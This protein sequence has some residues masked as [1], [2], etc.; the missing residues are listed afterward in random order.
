MD[1]PIKKNIR[2]QLLELND[3]QGVETFK[4]FNDHGVFFNLLLKMIKGWEQSHLKN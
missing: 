4:S 1:N 3:G 2:T